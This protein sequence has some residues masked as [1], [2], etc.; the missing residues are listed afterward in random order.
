MRVALPALALLALA[1][2]VGPAPRPAARAQ[3]DP[4]V[5]ELL[6]AMRDRLLLMHDVARWKWT[7]AAA[8]EDAAREEQL[9]DSLAA[10]GRSRGLDEAWTRR[11]FAAQIDAGKRIQRA[12]FDRWQRSGQGPFADAPDLHAEV[13]PKIDAAG[14]RI[15]AALP[16]IADPKDDAAF[17]AIVARRATTILAAPGIT[18]DV[19]AAALAPLLE[20]DRRP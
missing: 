11:F 18:P 10:E 13:R 2:L 6:T 5:D 8:I 17:R 15:L 4:A 7:H 19:R 1:L 12:D 20:P 14:K 3:A 9:L 16:E